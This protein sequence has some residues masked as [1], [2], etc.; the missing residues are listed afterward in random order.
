MS[1]KK[2]L[3]RQRA[4]KKRAERKKGLNP[5]TLFILV[6]GILLALIVVSVYVFGEAGGPGDPPW[7]GAVW[8]PSHGHW[9]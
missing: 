4:E 5:A 9:H 3:R 6:I 7:P 8:S 2:A 1:S